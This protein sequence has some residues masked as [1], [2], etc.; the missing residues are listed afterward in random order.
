[1]RPRQVS[2]HLCDHVGRAFLLAG[3]AVAWA[4]L[5]LHAGGQ[6]LRSQDPLLSSDGVIAE[7]TL[8]A[9][10]RYAIVLHELGQVQTLHTR[11]DILFAPRDRMRSFT[12]LQVDVG[13]VT[14]RESRTGRNLV[15]R[16]G[17]SIEGLQ[18][19]MLTGTVMLKQLLYRYKTV[20]RLTQQELVLVALKGPMAVLEK[21]VLRQAAAPPQ[22]SPTPQGSRPLPQISLT[23]SPTLSTLLRT[24]EID[25]DTFEMDG[26]SLRPALENVGQVLSDLKL[27]ISPTISAQAGVGFNVSSEVADGILNESGFTVTNSKA[28]Q[29][30]GIEVGD[31]VLRINSNPV[32]SPLNAWW[33][34]QDFVIRNPTQSEMRVDIRRAESLVTKTFRVR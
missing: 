17:N 5:D 34:Y 2:P 7:I 4:A 27:M 8:S 22:A 10:T 26:A 14:L 6:P 21:Q 33:A 16:S 12:I 18:G 15:W 19:L 13:S 24:K 3:L 31:T 23:R 11:N 9:P 25:A 29:I 1:M 32:T 28:A 30:F 20:E